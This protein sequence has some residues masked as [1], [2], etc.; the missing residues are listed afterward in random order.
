M[1]ANV[2]HIQRATKITVVASQPLLDVASRIPRALAA[3]EHRKLS[4]KLRLVKARLTIEPANLPV[5]DM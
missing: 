4:L 1:S 3:A 2:V 5:D